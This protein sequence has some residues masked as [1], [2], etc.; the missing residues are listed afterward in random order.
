[1]KAAAEQADLL[2]CLAVRA[3]IPDDSGAANTPV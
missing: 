3:Q 1:M 2:R